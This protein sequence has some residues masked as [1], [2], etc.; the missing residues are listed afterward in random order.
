MNE[1]RPEKSLPVITGSRVKTTCASD[2]QERRVKRKPP[3]IMSKFWHWMMLLMILALFGVTMSLLASKTTRG[4]MSCKGSRRGLGTWGR[5]LFS[6]GGLDGEQ[7][8]SY[9][10]S[11]SYHYGQLEEKDNGGGGGRGRG[12]GRSIALES[13]S[14]GDGDPFM[15]QQKQQQRKSLL[16]RILDSGIKSIQFLRLH[17]YKR[18]HSCTTTIT[19]QVVV[20][21]PG[22]D[23]SDRQDMFQKKMQTRLEWNTNERENYS[24]AF[25]LLVLSSSSSRANVPD[26]QS[27]LPPATS[28]GWT[29]TNG[30][31]NYQVSIVTSFRTIRRSNSSSSS[32]RSLSIS[33]QRRRRQ[34]QEMLSQSF[35]VKNQFPI[36]FNRLTRAAAAQHEMEDNKDDLEAEKKNM[37]TRSDNPI[38]LV[39]KAIEEEEEDNDGRDKE[40]EAEDESHPWEPNTHSGHQ[41][42]T[43]RSFYFLR[44]LQFFDEGEEE[45]EEV[46]EDNTPGSDVNAEEDLQEVEVDTPQISSLV[47]PMDLRNQVMIVGANPSQGLHPSNSNNPQ[48]QASIT[49][50]GLERFLELIR[51]PKRDK[52][53]SSSSVSV[54]PWRRQS[55]SSFSSATLP[56]TS[57]RNRQSQLFRLEQRLSR[58]RPVPAV[59]RGA[60]KCKL[61]GKSATCRRRGK[62]MRRKPS[63]TPSP[64]VVVAEADSSHIDNVQFTS[65]S[66]STTTSGHRGGTNKSNTR[67]SSGDKW[68]F[69]LE[70]FCA[71]SHLHGQLPKL[72]ASLEQQEAAAKK[73][74]REQQEAL[75]AASKADHGQRAISNGKEKVQ[76]TDNINL[77]NEDLDM[78]DLEDDE[79]DDEL[80]MTARTTDS[81]RLEVIKEQILKKLGLK[82]APNIT[83]T[84]TAPEPSSHSS[85]PPVDGMHNDSSSGGSGGGGDDSKRMV[86]KK[87]DNLMFGNGP[88]GIQLPNNNSQFFIHDGHTRHMD[89]ELFL[90]KELILATLYRAQ[91]DSG[92]GHQYQ[93]QYNQQN[94]HEE[95]GG[96]YANPSY[97]QPAN[98]L[99][100]DLHAEDGRGRRKRRKGRKR[101]RKEEGGVWPV[102][103]DSAW[104]EDEAAYLERRASEDLKSHTRRYLEE[105]NDEDEEDFDEQDAF[106]ER[107]HRYHW[108]NNQQDDGQTGGGDEE[109]YGQSRE[110]ITFAERGETEISGSCTFILLT[111]SPNLLV[112]VY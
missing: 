2:L 87:T 111:Q 28:S 23:V 102:Q 41:Q 34:H 33:P 6:K 17:Y 80:T 20:V 60:K 106:E 103:N 55:S 51:R 98:R 40:M 81:L 39:D 35:V 94:S 3:P 72:I 10:Y 7:Y 18:Q 45:D 4:G 37:N 9:N 85:P 44:K 110:I 109:S 5:Q 36:G 25:V 22:E 93:R 57:S 100:D 105:D 12:G 49:M 14:L 77:A 8:Y 21:I 52:A 97:G 104:D 50:R 54:A 69:I 83:N 27:D 63:A 92:V 95:G 59:A 11:N 26:P 75:A 38:V 46:G 16:Q 62:G 65:D 84:W 48:D 47:H 82:R 78:D 56:S 88:T 73:R 61:N 71:K 86:E 90:S 13:D 64:V 24:N 43:R 96:G 29:L 89:Q 67:K 74:Q 42:P 58:G 108:Q 53:I 66:K 30:H 70:N 91:L 76:Q 32:R 107:N 79:H 99:F 112:K 15:L 19:G 1:D 68:K 101:K 31:Q